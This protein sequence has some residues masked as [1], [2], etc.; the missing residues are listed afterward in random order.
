MTVVDKE[1][2]ELADDVEAV[3]VGARRCRE[4][5]TDE[6]GAFIVDDEWD[7]RVAELEIDVD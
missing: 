3:Q 5:A 6:G 7:R 1:G 2:V 4:V